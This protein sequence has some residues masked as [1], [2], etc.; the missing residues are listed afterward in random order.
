MFYG[1]SVYVEGEVEF[2]ILGLICQERIVWAQPD[3][4]EL[5]SD[6]DLLNVK[7]LTEQTSD[8]LHIFMS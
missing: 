6:E 7:H 8:T 4:A 1:F 3:R 5:P 2:V